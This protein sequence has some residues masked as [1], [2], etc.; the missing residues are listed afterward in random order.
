MRGVEDAEDGT[1]EEEGSLLYSK[2]SFGS[3]RFGVRRLTKTREKTSIL[4]Q[5][6]FIDEDKANDQ[7]YYEAMIGC[8]FVSIIGVYES[9]LSA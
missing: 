8:S 5:T 2:G 7:T 3:G 9:T 6:A 1:D 4:V